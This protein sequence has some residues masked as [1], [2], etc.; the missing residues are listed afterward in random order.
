MMN[1]TVTATASC[2][3]RPLHSESRDLLG[4]VCDALTILATGTSAAHI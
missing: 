3:N 4:D 2:T 1:T